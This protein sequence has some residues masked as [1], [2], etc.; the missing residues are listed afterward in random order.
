VAGTA[1]HSSLEADPLP[2]EFANLIQARMPFCAGQHPR[3]SPRRVLAVL[4]V[5]L[6]ASLWLRILHPLVSGP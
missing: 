3:Q 2:A 4:I 5:L 1:H 6:A